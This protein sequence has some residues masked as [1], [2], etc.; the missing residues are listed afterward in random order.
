[1][2]EGTKE[3]KLKI[4]DSIVMCDIFAYGKGSIPKK[5]QRWEEPCDKAD[6][7]VFS[8]HADDEIL[9]L[10]GV[11]VQYAGVEKL[12]VQLVY[13][14][15]YWDAQIIREHEK[16]DGIWETGVRNYPINSEFPDLYATSYEGALTV[17][18]EDEIKG[19]V[20]EQIRRFKPQVVVTQD[21]NGEYGHGGHQLLAHAVMDSV[22]NS[23]KEDYFPESVDK[24]GTFDVPKTYLHL[25]SEK[26]IKMNLREKLPE[27]GDRTAIEVMQDAYKLHVSQQWCWFY[28]SDEYEYS[29]ADFGMYRTTVGDDTGNDM[30]E[31]LTSYAEQDRIEEEKRKEEEAKKE[32][33]RL[34][35]LQDAEKSKKEE[36]SKDVKKDAGSSKKTK[37]YD[38]TVLHIVIII[39]LVI[40]A[41]IIVLLILHRRLEKKKTEKTACCQKKIRLAARETRLLKTYKKLDIIRF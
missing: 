22:D 1:M 4:K 6:I 34:A 3:C 15:T 39:I 36:N 8:T 9:F 24:Y 19:F 2:P 27:F 40:I 38:S 41:A 28:V 33:E 32:A 26:K 14:T 12:N 29:C 5:V 20:T 31:H 16:L 25:Y 11:L 18:N 37:S 17:Y 30:M 35:S 10:G 23:M 21:V 13:M 7:L